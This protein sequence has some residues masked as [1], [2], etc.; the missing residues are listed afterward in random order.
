MK[1]KVKEHYEHVVEFAKKLDIV[2]T[3]TDLAMDNT[4]ESYIKLQEVVERGRA[5]IN[6][7]LQSYE[8]A[9]NT[10]LDVCQARKELINTL[11]D[12]GAEVAKS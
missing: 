1:Q 11:L 6:V 8:N 4:E 3:T 9:Y 2:A 12:L 7:V 10:M 5:E